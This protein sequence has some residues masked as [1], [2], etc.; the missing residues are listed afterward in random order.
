MKTILL[1]CVLMLLGL[2][3]MRSGTAQDQKAPMSFFVTSEGPGNGANLG[4]LKGADAH[5]QKLAQAV[6]AVTAPGM[7]TSVPARKVASLP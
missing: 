7:P 2:F 4:G 6:G 5:C 3:T 1:A